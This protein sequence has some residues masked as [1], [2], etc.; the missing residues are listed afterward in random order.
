MNE[1]SSFSERIRARADRTWRAN[2]RHRF[3]REVATDAIAIASPP[4]LRVEY[5]FVD[6]AARRW[7]R[8]AK[9]PIEERWRLGLGVDGLSRSGAGP[10]DAFALMRAP[11]NERSFFCRRGSRFRSTRSSEDGEGEG[12]RGDPF[13]RFGGGVDVLAGCS[14]ASQSPSSRVYIRDSVAS[15][16]RF[17]T[18]RVG[19]ARKSSQGNLPSPRLCS[20]PGGAVDSS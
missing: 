1:A 20:A 9:A 11:S 17:A 15:V 13:L 6:T 5:G 10:A 8:V 12:L 19:S 3:F 7:A 4:I 2:L 16:G 18:C 14:A